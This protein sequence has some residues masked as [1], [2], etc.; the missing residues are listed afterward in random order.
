ML[1]LAEISLFL[2]SFSPTI[3]H[4]QNIHL[5]GL[6]TLVQRQSVGSFSLFGSAATMKP[7]VV[8]DESGKMVNE[9]AA[10]IAAATPVKVSSQP[11]TC[12]WLAVDKGYAYFTRKK[13]LDPTNSWISCCCVKTILAHL[14][15]VSST[16]WPLVLGLALVF[17]THSRK[18]TTTAA[19]LWV[20]SQ[21]VGQKLTAH[22]W[23]WMLLLLLLPRSLFFLFF[24]FLTDVNKLGSWGS[25]KKYKLLTKYFS[26]GWLF[27]PLSSVSLHDLLDGGVV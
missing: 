9:A 21:P 15:F 14:V 6:N 25:R 27:F 26:F 3:R 20:A 7:V 24:S 11:D 10:A 5:Y 2:F 4:T 13:M 17:K 19:A 16:G 12:S 8:L 23:K 18:C 1:L 22:S